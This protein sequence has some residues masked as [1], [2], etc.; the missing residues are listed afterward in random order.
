[1]ARSR[2]RGATAAL[3]LALATAGTGGVGA[4]DVFDLMAAAY[5]TFAEPLTEPAAEDGVA[6]PSG[7]VAE[8]R[9]DVTAGRLE[10]SDARASGQLT[11]VTN[12]NQL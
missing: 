7:F 2:R 5:F 10:A 11:M 1:M 4:E 8:V 3:V 9:G 6:E 12:V